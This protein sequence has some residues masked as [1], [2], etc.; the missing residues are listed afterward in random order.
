MISL[1]MSW[2]KTITMHPVRDLTIIASRD[3]CFKKD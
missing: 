3:N 1:A 2:I